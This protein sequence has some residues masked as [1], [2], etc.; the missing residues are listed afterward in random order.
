M[1][2]TLKAL[3]GLPRAFNLNKFINIILYVHITSEMSRQNSDKNIKSD[4]VNTILHVLTFS[5][6]YVIYTQAKQL[7]G[8]M[9]MDNKIIFKTRL[10]ALD[11]QFKSRLTNLDM[12]CTTCFGDSLNTIPLK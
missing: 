1:T 6:V 2:T 3:K 12:I 4:K 10:N 5:F 7:R 8:D 11:K 9:N